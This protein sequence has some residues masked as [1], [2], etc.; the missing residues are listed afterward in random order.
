MR[1][2]FSFE[3]EKEEDL[4]QALTPIL[5]R[6]VLVWTIGS[7]AFMADLVIN[8]A[9]TILALRLGYHRDSSRVNP[10][11]DTTPGSSSH[12]VAA[13]IEWPHPKGASEG[14]T[15]LNAAPPYGAPLKG[16][17]P[18]DR[19]ARGPSGHLALASAVTRLSIK[20]Y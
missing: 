16:A 5:W 18:A 20:S 4:H 1:F 2:F 12:L 14:R 8:L 11:A 9:C 17:L 3:E 7:Y 19:H 10:A 15:R 13:G 6:T